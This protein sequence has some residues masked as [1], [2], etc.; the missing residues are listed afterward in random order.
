MNAKILKEM[1]K[2]IIERNGLTIDENGEIAKLSKGYMVS[3]YGY[4]KVISDIKYLELAQVKRY[5][6]LAKKLNAFVGFWIDKNKIYLDL[7][8]N[9]S[10]KKEALKIAKNNKQL[11]IFDCKKLVSIHL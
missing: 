9:I 3:L 2:L 5:L 4:E 10:N 1:K 7:S 6:K 11:A 8:I